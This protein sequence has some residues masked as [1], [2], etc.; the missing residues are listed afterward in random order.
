MSI[1]HWIVGLGALGV[2]FFTGYMDHW[3]A[4]SKS[5][6]YYEEKKTPTGKGFRAANIPDSS[7]Y[8]QFY[9]GLNV[10]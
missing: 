5:S 6:N 2:F 8:D 9:S 7:E 10:R 3:C 1:F 4:K